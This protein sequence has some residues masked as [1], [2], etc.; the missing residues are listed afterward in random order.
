MAGNRLLFW[1]ALF[2]CETTVSIV[3]FRECFRTGLAV[4]LRDDLQWQYMPA[5]LIR[6]N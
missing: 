4:S 6:A 2:W 1:G 5:G 3:F